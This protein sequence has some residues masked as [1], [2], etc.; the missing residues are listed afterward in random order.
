LVGGLD[1]DV[2]AIQKLPVGFQEFLVLVADVELPIVVE[3]EM[4]SATKRFLV[5]RSVV[6]VVW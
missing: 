2:G 6:W 1:E 5:V 3:G 4:G